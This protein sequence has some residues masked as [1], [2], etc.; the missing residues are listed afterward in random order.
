M[1]E[2]PCRCAR[3]RLRTFP[4]QGKIGADRADPAGEARGAWK[5]LRTAIPEHLRL[6]YQGYNQR[7]V[8]QS[9]V[10]E[11]RQ[12]ALKSGAFTNHENF[13]RAF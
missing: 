6:Q 12:T 10:G 2:Q 9:W 8:I 13:W 11:S 3:Y 4:Y 5:R 1:P 7:R